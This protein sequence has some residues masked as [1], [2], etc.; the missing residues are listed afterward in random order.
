MELEEEV[1]KQ[2]PGGGPLTNLSLAIA[3]ARLNTR[4]RNTG[5]SA[6]EFW[7]QRN[8]YTHEQIPISD[9]DILE[10]KYHLRAENHSHSE[11]SKY[12]GG[13]FHTPPRVAVGDLVYLISDKDKLRARNL[14]LV[15]SVDGDW[16]FVKK[17]VGNQLRASSYNV[18]HDECYLVPGECDKFSSHTLYKAY[19]SEDEEGGHEAKPPEP[20][21]VPPVLTS[22]S[23]APIL[24]AKFT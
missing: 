6:R 11:N 12:H 16:C 7:T 1:L 9:Q 17:F 24:L 13:K 20:A 15:T 21:K 18:K 22:P 8:Q 5:L 2:E 23:E 3:V 19:E 14:Y 4:I 10:K